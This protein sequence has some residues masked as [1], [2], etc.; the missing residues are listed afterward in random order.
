MTEKLIDI[1]VFSKKHSHLCLTTDHPYRLKL[2]PDEKEQ[3]VALPFIV[4]QQ[5]TGQV[6]LQEGTDEL[7]PVSNCRVTL[8]HSKSELKNIHKNRYGWSF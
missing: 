6:L 4:Y 7:T 8:N 3:K 1:H 5:Y 2:N